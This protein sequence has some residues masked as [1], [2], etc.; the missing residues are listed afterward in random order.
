MVAPGV[1]IETEPEPGD[2]SARFV[3]Q[4]RPPSNAIHAGLSPRVVAT[5]VT[6]PAGWLGSIW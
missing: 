1:T 2:W 3:V 6:A 5:V 4:I